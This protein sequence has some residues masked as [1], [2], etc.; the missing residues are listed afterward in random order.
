MSM[1]FLAGLLLAVA[2]ILPAQAEFA[3]AQKTEIEGIVKQ[4]IADHPEMIGT[5]IEALQ[6]KMVAEEAQKKAAAVKENQGSPQV[7]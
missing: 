5:A 7:D 6:A 2:F 4:Y 1:R 3:P